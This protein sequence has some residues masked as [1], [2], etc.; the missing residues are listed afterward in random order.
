MRPPTT[1][2]QDNWFSLFIRIKAHLT[3][4]MIQRRISSDCRGLSELSSAK[5][6]EGV[7]E[8]F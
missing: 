8:A 6:G 3:V 7:S 2:V 5:Q 1:E 4:G